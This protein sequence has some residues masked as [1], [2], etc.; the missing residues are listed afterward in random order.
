VA[1]LELLLV[2]GLCIGDF[3]YVVGKSVAAPEN[4]GAISHSPSG[5]VRSQL[6]PE[7]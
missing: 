2:A 1:L 4:S 5:R 7:L 3:R 6:G